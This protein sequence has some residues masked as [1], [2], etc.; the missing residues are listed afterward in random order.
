MFPEEIR[1]IIFHGKE[2]INIEYKDSLPWDHG[3]HCKILP[4][5]LAMANTKNGG[6]II[7]GVKELAGGAF[8]FV[9]MED[10]HM[11]KYSN[12]N[13]SRVIV[14]YVSPMID[15]EYHKDYVEDKGEQ[16]FFIVI[17]VRESIQPVICTK[18]LQN[19][20]GGGDNAANLALRKNALYIRSRAPIGS[21]EVASESELRDLIERGVE[22]KHDELRKQIVT[23]I[24]PLFSATEKGR[25]NSER[26]DKDLIE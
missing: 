21:R 22:N 15:F 4:A 12:D 14:Q 9:G 25:S 2:E 20:T 26:H 10:S 17:R 1:E 7:I 5:I 18:K 16:K 11:Q 23:V 6:D 3:G 24:G 19:S 13:I 8:D